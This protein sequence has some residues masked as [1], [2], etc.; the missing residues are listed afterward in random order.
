MR[1]LVVGNWKMNLNIRQSELLVSRL[2][3]NIKKPSANIV[4]CPNF[5]S[6]GTVSNVV[7]SY[8]DSTFAVGAQNIYD[9]D[10]GAYTGEISGVMLKGLADFCIVGHSERRIIFGENDDLI[11][12]KVAACFRNDI[13]PVLCVGENLQQR[14]EKIAKNVVIDQLEQNL[15]EITP[16]EAKNVVIAYEPV[17][18]IGTGENARPY[19]VEEMLIE[20]QKYIINKYRETI[21]PKVRILYG[22][23][24]NG[25][26]AKSY[27]D[28]PQCDGLLV[29]GASLNYKDFSKICQLA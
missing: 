14:H 2:K 20:I 16:E 7:K 13:L 1:R 22:G 17:W 25:G 6:L 26:N 18:A 23:S 5:V 15:S 12:R 9:Q 27:L 28:L 29:G 21:A 10:E 8:G 11:A 4:L 3:A 19:D 24:V